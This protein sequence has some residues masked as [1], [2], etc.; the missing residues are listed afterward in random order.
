MKKIYHSTV[1]TAI[2]LTPELIWN[3]YQISPIDKELHEFFVKKYYE[4]VYSEIKKYFSLE[5]HVIIY[6]NMD[7]RTYY[8]MLYAADSYVEFLPTEKQMEF[9][10][11]MLTKGNVI[12]DVLNKKNEWLGKEYYNEYWYKDRI[13]NIYYKVYLLDDD[14][15]LEFPIETEP[16]YL[17]R[18]NSNNNPQFLYLRDDGSYFNKLSTRLLITDADIEVVVEEPVL[19]IE[20]ETNNKFILIF[21]FIIL[22]FLIIIIII[23][24]IIQRTLINYT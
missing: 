5:I 18:F 12:E 2:N 19:I 16:F 9:I 20:K 21:V 23:I 24:I 8:Q 13:Y 22:L 14:Y 6:E 7:L 1:N 15:Y 10:N 4:R 3:M 11:N 17:G